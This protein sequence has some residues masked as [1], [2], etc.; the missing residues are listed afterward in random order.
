[1]NHQQLTTFVTVIAEGSMT[2]AAEKLSLTQPAVSQ[3]IRNL[4]EEQGVNLLVRGTR[5]VKPTLPGQIL[6]D[7]AKRILHLTQQAQVAIQTTSQ[8]LVGELRISTYNSI[9]LFLVS[10]IMGMFLKHNSKLRLH[11]NYGKGD[12]IINDMRSGQVDVVILPDMR[13]EFGIEFPDYEKHFLFNDEMWLVGSGKDT[14]LPDVISMSEFT[15]K[16]V[17]SFTETYPGFRKLFE[18]RVKENRLNV[19]PVFS[20]DNVGTVKRVVESGLGWGFLP[21][22]AIK[23][24]VRGGRMLRVQVE[25]LKYSVN[26]NMYCLKN[27]RNRMMYDTILGALQQQATSS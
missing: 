13:S 23:K 9:G 20:T 22:H 1:M 27:E 14:T 15:T 2:A 6:Y 4:E 18:T 24:Q 17:V 26:V 11:L 5:Q 21:S 3:Q 16:P 8:D 12:K 19:E 25:D 7:Y 10:P